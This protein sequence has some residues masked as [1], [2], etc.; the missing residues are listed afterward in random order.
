MW[1][2]LESGGRLR[3]R[4]PRVDRAADRPRAPASLNLGSPYR[5]KL[6]GPW[7]RRRINQGLRGEDNG[8]ASHRLDVWIHLG[9]TDLPWPLATAPAASHHCA[10]HLDLES[11]HGGLETLTVVPLPKPILSASVGAMIST[12]TRASGSPRTTPANTTMEMGRWR[13]PVE[14]IMQ[15]PP[16]CFRRSSPQRDPRRP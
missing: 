2:M 4:G 14:Q 3:F 15:A 16:F 7:E 8:I 12:A 1:S 9:P 6:G 5:V 10:L 11:D 13:I